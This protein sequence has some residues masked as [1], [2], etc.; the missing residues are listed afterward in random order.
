MFDGADTVV[1]YEELAFQDVLPVVW[2]TTPTAADRDVAAS[3][4]ERNVRLLHALDAMD[5][6]GPVEKAED[7]AY[8]AEIARLD[9]KINLLLDLVGQIL[10]SNRPRPDPTPV[11][12]N[13]LGAMWRG[14]HPL[15]EAGA[16]GIAEIYLRDCLAEPLRL[17]GRVTSVTPDGHVKVKFMPLGEAVADLIEKLAFRRHRRQVAGTR[18]RRT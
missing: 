3:F 7:S 10:V 2:R 8:A 17:P 9:M 14:S 1:L 15:P 11:R 6:H 12:F 18:P 5:E 4:M 13:A 16:Q